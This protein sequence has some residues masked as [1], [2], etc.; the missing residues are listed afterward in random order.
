MKNNHYIVPDWPVPDS[1]KSII[2]TRKGG[3]STGPYTSLN[4]A[5]HVG[6]N[7]EN[8]ARN[9]QLISQ[10]IKLNSSPQWLEQVHGVDV[11]EARAGE[12]KAAGTESLDRYPGNEEPCADA[13]V[14]SERG[15]PCAVMTADCL[16][17]LF[18]NRSAD[19]VGV[20]HAGWRGLQAG[21]LENTCASFKESPDQL[22]AWLGPAIGP[23]QFEVGE[24]VRDA[25]LAT[26]LKTSVAFKANRDNPGHWFADL[27]LL[28]KIRLHRF[29]LNAIYGGDFC[30]YSDSERF[31]SY[32][33]DRVTGRMASIIWLE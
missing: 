5:F 24:E 12:R 33:R 14:T 20:A 29:G 30:T 27:Y 1:V 4:P 32:R 15:L 19:R 17:V 18:C 6:D 13:V 23:R 7:P 10:Q 8:V 25:F 21:V 11:F 31:F 16:P 26:S 9:R 28:A 3:V 22:M 2:T